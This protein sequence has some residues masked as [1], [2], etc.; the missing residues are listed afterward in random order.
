[1]SD[2]MTIAAEASQESSEVWDLEH[3]REARRLGD[4][5]FSQFEPFVGPTVVEVGA[6]IGTF[7]DRLLAVGVQRLLLIEPEASCVARLHADYD[8]DPRVTVVDE[9]IPKAPTLKAWSGDV[10]YLLCQNVLEHIEDDHG[11]MRAMAA[12]LRPGGRLTILVPANPRLYGQLDRVYGHHRR[13][14][15]AALVELACDSGL[16]VDDVYHFNM[17]GVPGWMLQNRRR[18]PRLSQDALRVYELLL[19][20]WQPVERRWRPPT[21]LSVVLQAHRPSSPSEQSGA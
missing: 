2:R 20:A 19:R 6:G 12:S 18:N 1:M 17:L 11:A 3:L 4:F 16:A 7:S 21:G 13:Y 14:T 10:D 8:D 5:M 9:L 15:K